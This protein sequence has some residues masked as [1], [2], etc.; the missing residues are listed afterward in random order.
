MKKAVA[1]IRASYIAMLAEVA[2]QSLHV[3]HALHGGYSVF[4]VTLTYELEKVYDD[5]CFIVSN[6]GNR[7]DFVFILTLRCA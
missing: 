7:S 2:I 5:L 1:E 3:L 4:L 6:F